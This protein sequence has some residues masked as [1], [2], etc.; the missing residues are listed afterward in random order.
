MNGKEQRA[1]LLSNRNTEET[2]PIW[3]GCCATGA[4][5]GSAAMLIL[6]YLQKEKLQTKVQIFALIS[7]K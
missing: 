5:A 6:E 2:V 4:E 3:H 1:A 7:T